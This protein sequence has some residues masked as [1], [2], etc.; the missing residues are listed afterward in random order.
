MDKYVETFVQH[1]TNMPRFEAP[2]TEIE[3]NKILILGWALLQIAIYM[4]ILLS[5]LKHQ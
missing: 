2:D 5:L 3:G 4:P 1:F